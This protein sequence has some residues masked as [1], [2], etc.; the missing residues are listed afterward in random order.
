MAEWVWAAVRAPVTPRYCA[1][2][3]AALF[4]LE[5]VLVPA[6]ILRVPC[7]IIMHSKS[8]R[9]IQREGDV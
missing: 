3:A 5:C 4:V 2:T 1:P 8:T 9:Q 7:E 6:I